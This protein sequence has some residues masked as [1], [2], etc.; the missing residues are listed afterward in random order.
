MED[1]P[2][3]PREMRAYGHENSISAERGKTWRL[4]PVVNSHNELL[5]KTQI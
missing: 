3:T 4:V 1:S 5:N 2:F